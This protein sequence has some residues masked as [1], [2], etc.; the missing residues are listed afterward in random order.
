MWLQP[1]LSC[2]SM[3]LWCV[4]CMRCLVPRRR[5]CCRR[6]WR[7][8]LG[9]LRGVQVVPPPYRPLVVAGPFGTGKR[10]L[11]KQVRL[12]WLTAASLG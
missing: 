12:L 2:P 8:P 6:L 4:G 3:C 9:D 10:L 7:C 11:L 1:E 5:C